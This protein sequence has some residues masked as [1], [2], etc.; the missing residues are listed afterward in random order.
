[1][2]FCLECEHRLHYSVEM[3]PAQRS[4]T[5]HHGHLKDALIDLAIEKLN[6]GA[7]PGDLSIRALAV[8]AGVSAGAPYR[9]FPTAEALVA[10]VAERGFAALRDMMHTA[11]DSVSGA[12]QLESIGVAYVQFAAEHPQWY[13]AMF[14]LPAH[15]LREYPHLASA[16]GESFAQL[17]EAVAAFQATREA[18]RMDT[19]DAARAAWAYVHG[20][21]GLATGSL[22]EIAGDPAAL[23]RLMTALTQGL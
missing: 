21:A 18:P 12:Q 13:R 1:M 20:L 7:E 23:R 2:E 3:A 19:A 22:S 11:A 4:D 6:G 10:A 5:Y 16:A 8:E 9:H 15:S 14:A 17:E